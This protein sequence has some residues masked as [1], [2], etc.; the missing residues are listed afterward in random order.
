M[1]QG[2]IRHTVAFRLCHERGSGEETAFLAEA[3]RL[4]SI[5]GVESFELLA[6]VGE[7]NDFD[8]GISME[9]ADRSAYVGYNEHPDHVAF[10]RDWWL[11][12]VSDFLELDYAGR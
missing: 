2:S 5:P 11:P 4:A 6:Q 10:V 7:K 1:R 3:E 12:Q 8:F 9:F